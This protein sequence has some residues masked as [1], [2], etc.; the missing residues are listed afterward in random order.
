MVSKP[1]IIYARQRQADGTLK[2][3]I[4]EIKVKIIS[5]ELEFGVAQIPTQSEL[6]AAIDMDN[7]TFKE[8]N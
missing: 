6:Q 8:E 4:S 7:G 3:F 2:L 1:F 5:E